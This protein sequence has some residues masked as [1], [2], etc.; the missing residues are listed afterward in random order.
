VTPGTSPG[1]APRLVAFL[2]LIVAAAILGYVFWRADPRAIAQAFAGMRWMP[3]LLVVALVLVDRTLMAHRWFV[4]LR[5]IEREHPPARWDV[6]KVFFVSTFVGTFLPGS[7][8]GDAARAYGLSRYGVPIS[9]SMASV[10]VDRM[11]G[12]LSLLVMALVGLI[13]ARDLAG[14]RGV[15]V[16]LAATFAACAV[17]GMLVFSNAADGVAE[18]LLTLVPWEGIRRAPARILASLRRY[19][20]HHSALA[21]V[22]VASVAVQ[23]LR[24][25][26]AYV[27]G[28]GIGVDAS[29]T[30]YFAFV[31]LVMLIMLLPITVNGIGTSQAAFV[32]FFSRVQTPAH[33]AFVLSVLFVGLQ[34]VGNIPGALIFAIE[35]LGQGKEPSEPTSP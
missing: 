8:G 19:S 6:L 25:V 34:V 5:P 26:Q 11:L 13:L 33:E 23:I 29:L 28:L 18:R 24:V 4:L 9:D 21:N 30:A 1:P 35:G 22:L 14:D 3:I 12:V 27:L 17:A 31:P 16:G 7:I 32:W 2:R 15:L 20:H 10:F